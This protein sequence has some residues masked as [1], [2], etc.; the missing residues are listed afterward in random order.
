MTNVSEVSQSWK[1][2]SDLNY[3]LIRNT[4]WLQFLWS[5]VI[6]VFFLFRS[7]CFAWIKETNCWWQVLASSV[8]FCALHVVF[9]CIIILFYSIIIFCLSC[10]LI[11]PN[12]S[13]WLSVHIRRNDISLSSRVDKRPSRI[14]IQT[15]Y[16]LSVFFTC[17][18]LLC[19]SLCVWV[20]GFEHI[21]ACVSYRLFVCMFNYVIFV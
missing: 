10:D 6:G 8:G 2:G 11:S 13:D 9:S 7:V 15:F 18:T 17:Q 3:F 1:L 14:Q 21:C 4:F 12:S 19:L 16:H 5:F 20:G